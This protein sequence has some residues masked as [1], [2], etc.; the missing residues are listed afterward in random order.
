M[1]DNL[2][3]IAKTFGREWTVEHLLPKILDDLNKGGNQYANRISTLQVLPKLANVLTPDDIINK[4]VPALCKATK[5]SVPN[6]R[7]SACRAFEG[8]L[9]RHNLPQATINAMVQQP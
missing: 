2:E 8:I 5:D 6:V 7:F 1:G 3:E 9:F 4:I